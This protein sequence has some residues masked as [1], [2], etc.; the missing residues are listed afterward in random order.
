MRHRELL[1]NACIFQEMIQGI[2]LALVR[3]LNSDYKVVVLI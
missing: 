1:N 2:E 3:P